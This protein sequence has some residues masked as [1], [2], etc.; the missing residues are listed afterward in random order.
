M[1]TFGVATLTI[2][3]VSATLTELDASNY[4][5]LS[6]LPS[7]TFGVIKSLVL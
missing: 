1:S 5:Y 2:S 7:I 3:E 6:A 4:G